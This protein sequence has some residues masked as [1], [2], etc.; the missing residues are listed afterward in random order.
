MDSSREACY[1][2]PEL[3]QPLRLH[4]DFP[5]C[6]LQGVLATQAQNFDEFEAR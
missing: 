6:S 3:I 5:K 4:E 2:H 1:R